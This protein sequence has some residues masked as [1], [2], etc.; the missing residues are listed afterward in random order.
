MMAQPTTLK[1]WPRDIRQFGIYDNPTRDFLPAGI[2]VF[3]T[4]L[5]ATWCFLTLMTVSDQLL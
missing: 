3:D 5:A 4:A 2:P 1:R